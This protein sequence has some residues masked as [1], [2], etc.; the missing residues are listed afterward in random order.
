MRISLTLASGI[1]LAAAS[2]SAQTWQLVWSDEFNGA[3]NTQPDATKWTY[4]IGNNGW[5]NNELENYTDLAENAH[6]DGLGHLDIHVENPSPGVYTSARI[7]TEGLFATEYGRIEARIKLPFGQGIWPAFW[8]L[9]TDITTVS[10]PQCG[11]IDIM[12]NIGSTPSIN[13]GSVHAPNYNV[14]AQY[15]LAN[16]QKLSD[17]FHTFAIQWSAQS[18]T[19]YVDGSSYQTI[20][21]SDAGSSWVFNTPFF[22]ILNVAVGGTF[23][24]SPNATT[25]FPQD[26]LV[27]YVRVYQA[28]TGAGPA[29]NTG[30]VVDAASGAAALAPGSLASAYGPSLAAATNSA[31]FDTAA[32]VFPTNASG[33][34]VYVNGVA[35]PLTYLSPMQINFA[36]PWD[37]LAGTP[38]NVEVMRDN[39]LS[40]PI[41][42]TLAPAAPSVLTSDGVTAL[43]TCP[44]GAPE[45]GAVCTLWGNGFG[46]TNPPLADGAPSPSA[47]LARTTTPCAL[48]IGSVAATVTYCGAAP[49]LII[50]QMNFVYPSGV[51]VTGSTSPAAITINDHTGNII[52]PAP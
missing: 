22:I 31:T 41:P 37:S 24:G 38:L 40:N 35:A 17:D 3:A 26:M 16:G 27:D 18:V 1:L 14:T 23:P 25:Q 39:L 42:I 36:V 30:G 45:P 8:M 6:M 48:T 47:T 46:P 21:Q 34:T 28:A 13:Y 29:L 11:E 15:P 19:F 4:D 10:W 12:E 52:V 43:L 32:G 5:G 7:K 2:L 51:A 20:T 9:G 50:Y 44:N 49:G 33:V